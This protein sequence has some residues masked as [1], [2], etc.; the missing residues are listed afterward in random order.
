MA[1]SSSSHLFRFF[2]W[3]YAYIVQGILIGLII[4]SFGRE[5]IR[6]RGVDQQIR[7]LQQQSEELQIKNTAISDLHNAVQTESFIEREARLKLDLKKPG[8]K[9][10]II[11]GLEG[12][13]K[14]N[15]INNLSDSINGVSEVRPTKILANSTKWWYYF[16]NKSVF[17]DLISY[18]K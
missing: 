3:R 6:R 8:E 11:K 7:S 10:L 5:V 15:F 4:F 12:S 9:L 2:H 18:D 13:E 17:N 16:F 1:R 14:N